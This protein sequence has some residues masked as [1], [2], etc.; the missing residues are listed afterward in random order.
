VTALASSTGLSLAYLGPEI[1]LADGRI[2]RG[3]GGLAQALEDQNQANILSTPTLLTL[4]NTEAKIVVGQNVPFVT[5]SY[6]GATGTTGAVNPFQTVER[7]DVG[8]TLQIKPQITEGGVVKME[9]MSEVSSV[10]TVSTGAA[11][12]LVTNKRTLETT[13]IIEDKS[14]VVLG[15]LIEDSADE[16]A[17]GVPFLSRIPILGWL[18]KYQSKSKKKTNLMVFLKP[19]IIRDARTSTSYTQDRYDY[20]LKQQDNVGLLGEDNE[21]LKQFSPKN[22]PEPRSED[23]R[24][25]E[26]TQ[27][28]NYL[29]PPETDGDEQPESLEEE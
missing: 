16:S 22:N 27:N 26:T 15:G 25:Y 13:V 28:D 3:L 1:V 20:I 14:T 24:L 6:T 29:G 21:M 10:N 4:D 5:G 12:D 7:K 8:L 17:Q 19:T 23:E 11:Q 9:I 2:I 18:F